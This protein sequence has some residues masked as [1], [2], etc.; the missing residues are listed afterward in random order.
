MPPSKTEPAV[1]HG[2]VVST[3]PAPPGADHAPADR[4][5]TSNAPDGVPEPAGPSQHPL[6]QGSSRKLAALL[7]VGGLIGLLAAAVLLL[8]KIALLADPDYV[9]SCSINPVLSCGSVMVTRQADAFGFPNPVLGV[10]GFTVVA[11]VGAALFAGARLRGWFWA[12]LQVGVTAGVVFVHWLIVQSLYSIEALCPYCMVVW[13]I[14]IPVFFHTSL[15]TA[16]TYL[17][18]DGPAGRALATVREYHG[19]V[20]TAWYLLVI[21]AIAVKFWTYWQTLFG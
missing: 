4:K 9:P 11:T 14:T 15:H 16:S 20:L 10:V 17:R 18:P 13:A 21:G 8:E 6:G 19:V 2:P 1:G 5:A 12:G 3:T 7:L